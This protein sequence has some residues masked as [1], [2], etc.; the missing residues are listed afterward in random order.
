MD[1]TNAQIAQHHVHILFGL[2]QLLGKGAAARDIRAFLQ[3]K[4][5]GRQRGFDLVG[6]KRIIFRRIGFAVGG[7]CRGRKTVALQS[8][9][10]IAIVFL[11]NIPGCRQRCQLGGALGTQHAQR[12]MP[13]VIPGKAG[14]KN[15]APTAPTRQHVYRGSSSGARYRMV[16]TNSVAPPSATSRNARSMRRQ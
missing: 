10:D 14:K 6:P 1:R 9:N 15:T 3:Q 4:A 13:A 16:T 2:E 7:V 8:G 5:H 11:Q 12:G